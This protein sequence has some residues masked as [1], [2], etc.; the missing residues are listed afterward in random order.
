[1]ER[2][3]KAV[4]G[5]DDTVGRRELDGELPDVEQEFSAGAHW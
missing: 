4:D 1:M 5:M 3:G 2:E